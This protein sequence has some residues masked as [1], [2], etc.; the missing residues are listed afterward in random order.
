[1]RRD[2]G[3][4]AD[5]DAGAAVEQQVRQARRQHLRLLRRGVVVR[6]E[7]DGVLV[8]VGEHLVGDRGQARFGVAHRRRAVAV[9]RAEVA[10]TID[11]RVAQVEVLRHADER[12]VDGGVAVRVDSS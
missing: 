7:I 10:L 9:D 12:V 11:E 6:L 5:G 1:M 4:H 8:D 2:V 3:R